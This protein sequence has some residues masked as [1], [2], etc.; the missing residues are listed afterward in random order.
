MIC[1][2][3]YFVVDG[4]LRGPSLAWAAP[5]VGAPSLYLL[6]GV[7]CVGP[8]VGPGRPSDRRR[9]FLLPSR[10][11]LRMRMS[12]C[13]ELFHQHERSHAIAPPLVPVNC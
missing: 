7:L 8:S 11:A 2:V 10:P 13:A 9:A 1:F 6:V 5:G 3:F 12:H 4:V